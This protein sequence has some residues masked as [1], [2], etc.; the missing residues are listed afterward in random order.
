[1]GTRSGPTAWPSG[2]A[3]IRPDF[4]GN[5]GRGVCRVLTCVSASRARNPATG[6]ALRIAVPNARRSRRPGMR[7]DGRNDGDVGGQGRGCCRPRQ[8]GEEKSLRQAGC[9]EVSPAKGQGGRMAGFSAAG[10]GVTAA[11][12]A[13]GRCA[14]HAKRGR[15]PRFFPVRCSTDAS[16]AFRRAEALTFSSLVRDCRKNFR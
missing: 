11:D 2:V 14:F 3:A 1:M 13:P 15:S 12:G 16:P 5:E 10:R 7:C 9:A 4:F 8:H 6:F